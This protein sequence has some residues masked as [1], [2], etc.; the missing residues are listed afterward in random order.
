MND[1]TDTLHSTWSTWPA[2]HLSRD[3]DVAVLDLELWV[4]VL[5]AMGWRNLGAFEGHGCFDNA[6]NAA[7]SLGVSNVGLH[8]ANQERSILA[9]TLEHAVQTLDLDGI[10]NLGTGAVAFHIGNT[11]WVEACFGQ[12]LSNHHFLAVGAG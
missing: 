11:V 9:F 8:G 1:L 4:D 12:G 3:Q 10:S 6:R 7:C 5:Q 2:H